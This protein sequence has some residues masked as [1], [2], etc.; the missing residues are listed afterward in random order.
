ML[1]ATLGTNCFAQ[2]APIKISNQLEI[3]QLDDNVY[4]YRSYLQTQNFG[5]VG[6]NG[7]L[8]VKNGKALLIDTPWD[9]QQTQQL[10][11]WVRD[12]LSVTIDSFVATH[13]HQDCMGGLGYLKTKAVR[14]YANQRTID[15]ARFK[16]LPIPDTA[17]TDSLEINFQGIP[18]KCYYLGA[19]HTTDNIVVWLPAQDML[20]G[21]CC[22]KDMSSTNLGN[23]EDADLQAWPRTLEAISTKFKN[24]KSIIPG[25]GQRGDSKLLDHTQYLLRMHKQ[26][27]R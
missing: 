23:L 11:Q 27:V 4:L 6:A 5:L 15:V 24:A 9:N 13:W 1:I 16:N 25:H 14:S 22:V 19:G 2:S 12:S 20:F 8:I 3:Q 10:Y 18:L 7:L 21:G 26:G 17:F